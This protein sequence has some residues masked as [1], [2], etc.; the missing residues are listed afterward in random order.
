MPDIDAE[1]A[2]P[3]PTELHRVRRAFWRLLLYS[4]LFH[5]PNPKYPIDRREKT[6]VSNFTRAFLRVVTIWEL[7]EIECVYYHLRIQIKLWADPQSP[8]YSP[9]LASRLLTTFGPIRNVFDFHTPKD[10]TSPEAK[11]HITA[12]VGCYREM[13][14]S[15]DHHGKKVE[16]PD[17]QDANKPNAGWLYLEGNYQALKVPE[18]NSRRLPVSCFLDWGYCIWDRSR[19]ESWWLVD[20]RGTSLLAGKAKSTWWSPWWKHCRSLRGDCAHCASLVSHRAEDILA[21]MAEE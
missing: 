16:W 8:C 7:E 11:S 17:T 15:F 3:S 4:D 13:M 19:L 10:R 6:P 5:E 9:I 2:P 1:P 12:M 14:C 21:E 20:R 18:G